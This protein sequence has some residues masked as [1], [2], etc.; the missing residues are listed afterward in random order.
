MLSKT[1]E[2]VVPAADAKTET[3][4]ITKGI[5]ANKRIA[6]PSLT[7]TLLKV[8]PSDEFRNSSAKSYIC[9]LFKNLDFNVLQIE[10]RTVVRK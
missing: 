9:S 4:L 1:T 6:L 8:K 2:A 7:I 3:P 5:K 10:H